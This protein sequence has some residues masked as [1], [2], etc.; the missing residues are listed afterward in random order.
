MSHKRKIDHISKDDGL[1]AAYGIHDERRKIS[2]PSLP[3]TVITSSS[4]QNFL[5]EA[6]PITFSPIDLSA[7]TEAA[8]TLNEA[9]HRNTA[10]VTM[11]CQGSDVEVVD[12]ESSSGELSE[13]EYEVEQ[14][15]KHRRTKDKGKEYLIKWKGYDLDESTWEPEENLSGSQS[16]IQE[17]QDRINQKVSTSPQ[18][19]VAKT[20]GNTS[21]SLSRQEAQTLK[22][23][24]SALQTR[25][26][27]TAPPSQPPVPQSR[28]PPRLSANSEVVALK[29]RIAM[30]EARLEGSPPHTSAA[31]VPTSSQMG[32]VP[33]DVESIVD[34]RAKNGR[35]EFLVRWRGCG[36]GADTWMRASILGGA[37]AAIKE[38]QSRVHQNLLKSSSQQGGL[39]R[40][41]PSKQHHMPLQ[42]TPHAQATQSAA[43]PRA[44][45]A[46]H[47]PTR[48]IPED[49]MMVVQRRWNARNLE[50]LVRWKDGGPD[51]WESYLA[52]ASAQEAIRNYSATEAYGTS[53]SLPLPK[54][55]TQTGTPS[56]SFVGGQPLSLSKP[57]APVLP[58]STSYGRL[59]PNTRNMVDVNR[60]AHAKVNDTGPIKKMLPSSVDLATSGQPD[61]GH[62]RKRGRP[63]KISSTVVDLTDDEPKVQVVQHTQKSSLPRG[64]AQSARAQPAEDSRGKQAKTAFEAKSAASPPQRGNTWERSN[65]FT[66]DDFHEA[67]RHRRGPSPPAQ[68]EKYLLVPKAQSSS[69]QRPFPCGPYTRHT[70]ATNVLLAMGKHPWL[71]KLNAR[72]DGLLDADGTGRHIN[73]ARTQNERAIGFKRFLANQVGR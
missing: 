25:S 18:R 40:D 43:S 49:I 71:S 16:F 32:R 62:K 70:V 21:A 55:S 11:T 41:L 3:N 42:N 1:A 35:D 9:A 65:N 12:L 20:Q 27:L 31:H 72:L 45:N 54:Q 63:G 73:D 38:Y 14:V 19:S 57:P 44:P 2:T 48:R 37:K 22:Q 69:S 39:W 5:R 15:L 6:K 56:Y 67:Y 46:P 59:S 13:A 28:E 24:A 36:P 33:E 23:N 26:E 61:V 4:D 10:A 17:Y 29:A 52:L 64:A 68:V 34:R 30:L 8:R 50:Y 58:S 7:I 51:T 60:A 66:P 53:T 47:V